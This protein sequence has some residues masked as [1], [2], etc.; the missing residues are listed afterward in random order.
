MAGVPHDRVLRAFEN[1]MEREC[2]LDDPEVWREM[3]AGLGRLFDQ[4]GAYFGGKFHEL[5]LIEA[6]EVCRRVDRL[7]DGHSVPNAPSPKCVAVKRSTRSP[8][9]PVAPRPGARLRAPEHGPRGGS[10]LACE[11]RSRCA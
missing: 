9:W 2:Q 7:E 1:T 11:R 3:P 6:A 5:G 10:C 4:E 8:V